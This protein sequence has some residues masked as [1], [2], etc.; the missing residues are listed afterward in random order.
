MDVANSNRKQ[1]ILY[2]YMGL[3]LISTIIV[4][5]FIPETK[6]LPV[7]EIAGLFGDKVVVHLSADRLDA[8]GV[9]EVC[10]ENASEMGA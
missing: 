5:F 7:E 6:R 3:T 4:Y 9:K 1:N 10:D 2:L 8:V